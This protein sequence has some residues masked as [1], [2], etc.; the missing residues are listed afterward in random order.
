MHKILNHEKIKEYIEKIGE[1]D[2]IYEIL[3]EGNVTLPGVTITDDGMEFTDDIFLENGVVLITKGGAS[4][5]CPNG[6]IQTNVIPDAL[7]PGAQ[8]LSLDQLLHLVNVLEQTGYEGRFIS[9]EE[10]HNLTWE[11][12]GNDNDFFKIP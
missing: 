11:E 8:K 7:F 5:V 12:I 2:Y 9:L 10:L 1:D 4:I 3:L 6:M